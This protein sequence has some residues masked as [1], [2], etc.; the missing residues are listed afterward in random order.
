MAQP[1]PAY[2]S[3]GALRGRAGRILHGQLQVSMPAPEGGR[4]RTYVHDANARREHR[5]PL[6]ERTLW[7]TPSVPCVRFSRRLAVL[8]LQAAY[9]RVPDAEGCEEGGGDVHKGWGDAGKEG[10]EEAHEEASRSEGPAAAVNSG[11]SFGIILVCAKDSRRGLMLTHCIICLPATLLLFD[12][13]AGSAFI[14]TR[15]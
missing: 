1:L 13:L 12:L 11:L 8:R 9:P 3:Q 15:L 5:P 4:R 2:S 10:E 6:P 7:A 14:T